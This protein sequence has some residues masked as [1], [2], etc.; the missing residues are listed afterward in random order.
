MENLMTEQI[1][2]Q[3]AET[4]GSTE[5]DLP[6]LIPAVGEQLRAAREKAGLQISEVALSLK[7]GERQ[8]AALENGDWDKLPG[9][10]F[11]RGF[12]RN[13]ARLLGLD[14]LPLMTQLDTVLAKPA[15]VLSVPESSTPSNVSYQSSGARDDR[16]FVVFGLLAALIAALVY[17]LLPDDLAQLREQTQSVIDSL[18][19]K[20]EPVVA[21]VVPAAPPSE[22]VFPP[23]STPQ[24][25]MNPQSLAP[26]EQP[27]TA[28]VA[29][30]E[31]PAVAASTAALSFE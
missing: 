23:G 13:Y 27:P 18:S 17:L 1:A 21:P 3:Q 25:I 20:E 8:L 31:K 6:V 19:R 26:A 30:T 9:S 2:E 29:T 14:P 7:L 24:Q 4:A 5:V 16:R 10:T 11:I 15:T 28:T 22:P 12:I